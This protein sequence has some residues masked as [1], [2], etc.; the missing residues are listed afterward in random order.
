M[1][2]LVDSVSK[3]PAASSRVV[4]SYHGHILWPFDVKPLEHV[5]V[6]WIMNHVIQQPCEM[7]VLRNVCH[8]SDIIQ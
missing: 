6:T 3:I 2:D 7:V 4:R 5:L 8:G 1:K